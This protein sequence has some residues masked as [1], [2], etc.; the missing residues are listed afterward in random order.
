[1]T[2]VNL[3]RVKAVIFRWVVQLCATAYSV[4]EHS[5]EKS[6]LEVLNINIPGPLYLTHSFM[7]PDFLGAMAVFWGVLCPVPRGFTGPGACC[8]RQ[9]GLNR[10]LVWPPSG[11]LALSGLVFF[12]VIFQSFMKSVIDVRFQT[13]WKHNGGNRYSFCLALGSCSTG[14]IICITPTLKIQVISDMRL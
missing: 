14:I 4:W 7:C 9:D 13:H 2:V 12:V 10:A 6:L 1:M 8:Q 11:S 5:L 3:L